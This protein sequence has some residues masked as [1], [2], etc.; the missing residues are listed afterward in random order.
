MKKRGRKDRE[1]DEKK[2]EKCR[3][4]ALLISIK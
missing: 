4:T 3:V 1:K 2:K